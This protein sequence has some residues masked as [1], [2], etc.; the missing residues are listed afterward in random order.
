MLRRHDFGGERQEEEGATELAEAWVLLSDD[1]GTQGSSRIALAAAGLQIS[2]G[3][4]WLHVKV[5]FK[6]G[7]R[8]AEVM[9]GRGGGRKLCEGL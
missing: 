4:S 5:L 3:Q 1:C 9:A 8:R 7:E 6:N 2:G